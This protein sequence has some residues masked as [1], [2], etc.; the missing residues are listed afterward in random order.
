M[1]GLSALPN[2]GRRSDTARRPIQGLRT[3]RRVAPSRGPAFFLSA[4][5][6]H[7]VPGVTHERSPDAIDGPTGR[8][9]FPRRPQS[10]PDPGNGPVGRLSDS[11]QS[12]GGPVPGSDWLLGP[13]LG[14]G[15]PDRNADAPSDHPLASQRYKYPRRTQ[16]KPRPASDRW[17][18]AGDGRVHQ[19]HGTD[20]R[21]RGCGSPRKR[22]A[23]AGIRRHGHAPRGGGG[24]CRTCSLG[25][26]ASS[27]GA[28]CHCSLQARRPS[29]S[30]P[31][32][33]RPGAGTSSASGGRKRSERAGS[34][35]IGRPHRRVT[36]LLNR[37]RRE[38]RT[39]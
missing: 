1:L 7:G 6:R 13:R 29:G 33:R 34:R 39:W 19:D 38:N 26:A 27:I 15:T 32:A 30:A 17:R 24:R 4:H 22:K 16:E 14:R 12:P 35:R 20:P 31:T 8:S 11:Q 3:R 5:R 28:S 18:A 25:V 9:T 23:F 2:D 37:K 21:C 36:R 10:S